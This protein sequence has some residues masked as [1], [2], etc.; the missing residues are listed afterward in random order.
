V[1]NLSE[2]GALLE[3]PCLL[4][5][6]SF[7]TLALALGRGTLMLL[8]ATALRSYAH[9]LEK[10][11]DGEARVRY[12]AALHF[13]D[14]SA[15]DL[16]LLRLRIAGHELVEGA[17]TP[18]SDAEAEAPGTSP[19]EASPAEP[20]P[21]LA[22][23]E[24]RTSGRIDLA[25][26]LECEVGLRVGLSVLMLSR[27]GMLVQMPFAPQL[28]SLVSCSLKI[29]GQPVRLDAI[30]RHA[31]SEGGDVVSPPQAVGLEFLGLSGP[32]RAAIEAYVVRMLEA[33]ERDQ[34]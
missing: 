8:K 6:R 25:G 24:R 10:S 1:L 22:G 7:Y 28:A 14:M 26:K 15:R 5:P 18:A 16:V 12:H 34:R 30:V 17:L 2:G 23:A 33:S 27:G 19:P 21:R 32:A 9:R 4:R 29:D 20:D 11:G 31:H 3:V 13:V